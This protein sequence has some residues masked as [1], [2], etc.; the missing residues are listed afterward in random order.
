MVVTTDS[1]DVLIHP[2][3]LMFIRTGTLRWTVGLTPDLRGLSPRYGTEGVGV[4][5]RE[6]MDTKQE[7]ALFEGRGMPP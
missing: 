2:P 4:E 6:T 1:V 5:S 7:D 3:S